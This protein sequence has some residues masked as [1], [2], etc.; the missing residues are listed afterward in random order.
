MKKKI[1]KILGVPYTLVESDINDDPVL[2]GKAGYC[3]Y[4]TKRIVIVDIEKSV[5]EGGC[6]KHTFIKG[7]I[8]HEIIHA[9]LQESGLWNQYSWDEEQMVDWLALQFPKI[10]KVFSDLGVEE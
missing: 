3:D 9:F 6:D 8:R 4:T 2:D 10:L 1:V 7:V 5:F